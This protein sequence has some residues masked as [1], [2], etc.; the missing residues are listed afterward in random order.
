MKQ[1]LRRVGSGDFGGG[2]AM[3]TTPH[4]PAGGHGVWCGRE[5]YCGTVVGAINLF[6]AKIEEEQGVD[7]LD[8]SFGA[9]TR[10][11][12]AEASV[13]RGRRVFS[14]SMTRHCS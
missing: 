7:V 8:L 1:V 11:E 13:R 5:S 3:V 10:K 9:W 4:R 2:L 14:R 6:A 12:S